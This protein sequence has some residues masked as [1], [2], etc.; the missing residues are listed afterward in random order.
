M[1]S[2]YNIFMISIMME[3]TIDE[4]NDM[5]MKLISWINNKME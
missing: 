5:N 2:N 1:V 3:N 4:T